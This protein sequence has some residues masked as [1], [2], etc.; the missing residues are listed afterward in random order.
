MNLRSFHDHDALH[1][2]PVPREGA[3]EG[4]VAWLLGSDES[5]GLTPTGFDQLGGVQDSF[6]VGYVVFLGPFR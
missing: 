6:V 3:D 5:Q 2:R 4:V 1:D